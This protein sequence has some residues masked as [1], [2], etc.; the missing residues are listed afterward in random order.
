MQKMN[1]QKVLKYS[2]KKYS[3]FINTLIIYNTVQNKL[4]CLRVIGFWKETRTVAANP[5][6][7]WKSAH[8]TE[9]TQTPP[10]GI[11]LKILQRGNCAT[12]VVS[13]GFEDR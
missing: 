10:L 9:K 4:P 8:H 6:G 12:L 1:I 7:H 2:K 5:C 3:T 13:A 11:E